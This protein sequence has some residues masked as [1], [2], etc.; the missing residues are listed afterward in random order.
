MADH[1]RIVVD[2]E[3]SDMRQS[4]LDALVHRL[5]EEYPDREANKQ[6]SG[7]ADTSGLAADFLTCADEWLNL[8]AE[9]LEER[10]G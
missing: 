3:P 2:G 1:G 9:E 10:L 7:P 4:D 5:N 6:I 8:D